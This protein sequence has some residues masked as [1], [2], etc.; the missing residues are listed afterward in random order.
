MSWLMKL[1]DAPVSMVAKRTAVRLL[2]VLW[3]IGSR[4]TPPVEGTHPVSRLWTSTTF[5]GPDVSSSAV[6]TE[7]LSRISAI[8]A[9]MSRC[10]AIPASIP[11]VDSTVGC[12]Y[13]VNPSMTRLD[14]GGLDRALGRC[15]VRP[16]PYSRERLPWRLELV[17]TPA[18]P[19]S[20]YP[21]RSPTLPGGVV[22]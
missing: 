11:H 21:V 2:V 5:D 22:S 19:L 20:R 6:P 9:V 17:S 8:A 13:T 4:R 18:R 3:W 16:R 15:D 1:L 14:S 7:V 10:S 12:C